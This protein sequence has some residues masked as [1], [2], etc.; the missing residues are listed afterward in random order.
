MASSI[1]MRLH[2]ITGRRKLG[3]KCMLSTIGIS[4][5]L[6]NHG[7]SSTGADEQD[8]WL[9]F[10]AENQV[11]SLT[12]SSFKPHLVLGTL[13]LEKVFGPFQSGKG[14]WSNCQSGKGLWP[15][16]IWKRSLVQLSIWKRS[17]APFVSH[18]KRA[19][20]GWRQLG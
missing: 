8:W 7:R 15:L 17:L 9:I 18:T 19:P 1:V 6:G 14:L 3:S 11:L 2:T 16:S 20:T 5:N 12:Q 10:Q 4:W 13:N